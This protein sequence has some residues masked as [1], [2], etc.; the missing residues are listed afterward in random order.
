MTRKPNT[1]P[2]EMESRGRTGF[3]SSGGAEL[4]RSREPVSYSGAY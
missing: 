3:L 1:L 2:V 4:S